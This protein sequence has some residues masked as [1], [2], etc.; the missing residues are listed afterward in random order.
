MKNDILSLRNLSAKQIL[1]ILDLASNLKEQL[2]TYG[3]NA[4]YLEGKI[5]GMVFQKPSTR[6]RI[7][8][9]TAMLQLGGNAINLSFNDLQLSR[10]ESIE[11]TART[12]SLYLDI[13]MARVYDHSDIEKLSENA[14][15]PVINGLSDLFHPCQIL[16]D[17]LTIFEYKR[18]FKDL[19]LAFIGDG[20]NVCNDLLL[21]CPKMGMD[22]RVATPIGFEPLDWVT[23]IARENAILHNTDLL[24][25]S[26]PVEAITDADVVV[27]DTYISIGKENEHDRREKI[28]LPVY[29]VNS[30][31]VQHAKKDFIF[32]HCLPAKREKEVSSSIIDGFH[33]V[34][35]SEAENRLH[36]QKALLLM[37]LRPEFYNISGLSD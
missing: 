36:T 33:S 6:T 9:E 12:L 14:K 19:R 26:D 3:A 24:I 13:L 27:T 20:N 16:A 4:K 18:K 35:W 22:I 31:L 7:S 17:F 8:F 32:M 5:L 10:G 25:T 1:N 21:G 34:V 30:D 11:D 15:I 23:E 28:F 29:Q 2:L 37:L